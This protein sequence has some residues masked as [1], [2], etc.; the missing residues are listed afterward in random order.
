MFAM[1]AALQRRWAAAVRL[2]LGA[3][4]V[5]LVWFALQ[6]WLIAMYHYTLGR[7]ASIPLERGGFL[8]RWAGAL[9]P[10]LVILSLLAEFGALWLLFPIGLARASRTLRL[11]ALAALPVGAV[12]INVQQPDRALWNFHFVVIPASVLV[13]EAAPDWVCWTFVATFGAANL[14]LGAQLPYVPSGRILLVISLVPAS[15]ALVANARR[16]STMID[17]QAPG[18]G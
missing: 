17:S 1:I 5:T 12:L 13:L 10:R 18:N 15:L 3:M 4:T 2:L 6:T 8:S 14:R 11:I 9:A 7:S 16:G